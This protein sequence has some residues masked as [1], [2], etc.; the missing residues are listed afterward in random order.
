MNNCNPKSNGICQ[1]N[2]VEYLSL[3]GSRVKVKLLFNDSGWVTVLSYIATVINQILVVEFIIFNS[4]KLAKGSFP[5][6]TVI[7]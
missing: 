2:A 3:K 4:L 6:L 5:N 1:T 7:T